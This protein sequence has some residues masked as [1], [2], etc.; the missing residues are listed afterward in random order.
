MFGNLK[1]LT[2]RFK[3]SWSQKEKYG[4]PLSKRLKAAFWGFTPAEWVEYDLDQ[5]EPSEYIS[6]YDR[7]QFRNAASSYRI[8]LDN[9]VVFNSLVKNFAPVNQI[10]GYKQGRFF[11]LYKGKCQIEILDEINKLVFKKNSMGGGHGFHL[12]ELRQDGYYIDLEKQEKSSVVS[13]LENENNYLLE[14]YCEQSDFEKKMFPQSVNTIRVITVIDNG[15]AVPILACHRMGKNTN[16]LVDNASSDGLVANIDMA[17]GVMRE[18]TSY[19]EHGTVTYD[20][21]PITGTPIKGVVIPNWEYVKEQVS[22]FHEQ[23]LFAKIPLLAW[24][25]ALTNDG[26]R[27]IEA[28]TSS[29][30]RMF[31]IQVG[32]LRNAPLGLWFKKNKYI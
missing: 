29:G 5:N 4:L 32:G 22:Y 20:V 24:D 21:H 23:M 3:F 14:D 11:S 17:S 15:Y 18:A 10:Y 9:K 16:S 12:L 30:L 28:N 25:V 31:Q 26:I 8:L 27:I 2:N 19:R 6:E 7:Y 1:K 13:L